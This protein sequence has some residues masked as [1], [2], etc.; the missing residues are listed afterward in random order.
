M[1]ALPP[2]LYTLPQDKYDEYVESLNQLIPLPAP[3]QDTLL[4]L[5]TLWNETTFTDATVGSVVVPQSDGWISVNGQQVSF[6]IDTTTAESLYRSEAFAQSEVGIEGVGTVFNP[7]VRLSKEYLLRPG[8]LSPSLE[9]LS[10][11]EMMAAVHAKLC[12]SAECLVARPYKVLS[13]GPGDFFTVHCDSMDK[14]ATMV[15][16]LAVQIPVLPAPG[17]EAEQCDTSES[18]GHDLPPGA[19]VFYVGRSVAS[20]CFK[21]DFATKE[22][23]MHNGTG[24][25]APYRGSENDHVQLRYTVDLTNIRHLRDK[26]G[27]WTLSYAGW[28]G[29]IPHAVVRVEEGYRMVLIYKLFRKGQRT[30]YLPR[31]LVTESCRLIKSVLEMLAQKKSQVPERYLGV[32]LRHKYPPA[33]LQSDVLKGVD[34][35]IHRIVGQVYR[36]SL[37]T[38]MEVRQDFPMN[39]FRLKSHDTDDSDEGR[40]R[41][42]VFAVGSSRVEDLD[43]SKYEAPREVTESYPSFVNTVWV[44][45]GLG[46]LIGGGCVYG[47]WDCG[48]DWWYRAAV[49]LIHPEPSFW[50]R[51]RGLHLVAL[52]GSEANGVY[53]KRLYDSELVWRI[54]CSFI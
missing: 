34:A 31:P 30:G 18:I 11:S 35:M 48:T 6:P 29:D 37:H 49:L 39:P 27:A 3:I 4:R 40:F 15:G 8:E 32:I 28:F 12:P 52:K 10:G 50:A 43:F 36:T 41:R 5:E 47:N 1:E 51:S 17:G 46:K 33:G 9:D 21:S 25:H 14:D 44:Q 38:A 16:S 22:E 2:Y 45:V 24:D 54:V 53:L 26:A 13:Y 20:S 19:L 23:L 42:R 7:T